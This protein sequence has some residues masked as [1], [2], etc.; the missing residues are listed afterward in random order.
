M[1]SNEGIKQ[2]GS[3]QTKRSSFYN[4]VLTTRHLQSQLSYPPA[5]AN[6][7]KK[8]PPSP[9]NIKTSPLALKVPQA[10]LHAYPAF[11]HFSMHVPSAVLDTGQQAKCLCFDRPA[12][13]IS[14]VSMNKRRL[15]FSDRGAGTESLLVMFTDD[16][17]N[18]GLIK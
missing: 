1:K 8:I 9:R 14:A 7:L 5:S 6:P 11:T 15:V 17:T 16:L 13:L 18:C 12:V 3:N 4:V 2:P 10:L